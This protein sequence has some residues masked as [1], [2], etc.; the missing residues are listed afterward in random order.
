MQMQLPPAPAYGKDVNKMTDDRAWNGTDEFRTLRY[1]SYEAYVEHQASKL[2]HMNLT[3]YTAQFKSALAPRL[4]R[5]KSSTT[6]Q[7]RTVLCLG[8][9]NGAECEAFIEA[10]FFAVGIDLNPGEA[11]RHVL[12]GDFHHIQFPDQTVDVVFTNTI[13]HVFDMEKLLS[14]VWR[15]LRPGGLFAAEIVRGS[16]DDGGREPG[17]FEAAWWDH[18]ATVRDQISARGFEMVSST[19]FAKP[20]GGDQH[21]FRKPGPA[22]RWSLRRLL[23]LES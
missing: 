18:G 15:V 4:E 21:V 8:A 3:N 6:P 10:G 17:K 2:R 7:Q 1:E 20:W 22:E 19:P 12:S 23:G 16:K 14:E 13:D 5:I 9:R 11:N